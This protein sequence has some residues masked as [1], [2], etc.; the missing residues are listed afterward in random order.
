MTF[1]TYPPN[2]LSTQEYYNMGWM[3]MSIALISSVSISCP[4]K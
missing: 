4:M 3:H 2:V 1:R